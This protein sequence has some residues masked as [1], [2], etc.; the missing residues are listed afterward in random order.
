ML[1]KYG[2]LDALKHRIRRFA[3]RKQA[4][5]LTYHSIQKSPLPFSVWHHLA[6]EHF[7]AQI[8]YLAANFRCVSLSALLAQLATGRIEPY[9]V[10]ITFDDGFRDNASTAFPI[11]LRHQV[12]ATIFLTTEFVGNTQLLCRTIWP[13]P[14]H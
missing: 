3:G 6:E 2:M 8:A 13:V 10:A 11:L 1:D 14:W 4:L 5:V 7:E 9:S 12:P